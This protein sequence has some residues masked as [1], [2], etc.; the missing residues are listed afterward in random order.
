[1]LRYYA[2][3]PLHPNG[4]YTYILK[5]LKLLKY[6]LHNC[7]KLHNEILSPQTVLVVAAAVVDQS[8]VTLKNACSDWPQAKPYK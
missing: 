1:M 8:H 6:L 4:F 3:T 2:T 7:T 5:V